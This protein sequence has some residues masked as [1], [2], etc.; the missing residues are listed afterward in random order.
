MTSNENKPAHQ[1]HTKLERPLLGHFGR[2]ELAILG[3]PCGNIKRLA[4]GLTQHL[5]PKFK[6]AYVDADHKSAD[7][8]A[9][10][11][12]DFN[13][14]LAHGAFIEYTDKSTFQ[15]FDYSESF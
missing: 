3:T 1:K 7:A 4:F 10:N 8:E 5:V 9:A 6:V 14:A 15:R 2:T 11:G 12:P 13:T